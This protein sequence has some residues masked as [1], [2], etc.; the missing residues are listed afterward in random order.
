[1]LSH[2]DAEVGL[3]AITEQARQHDRKQEIKCTSAQRASTGDKEFHRHRDRDQGRDKHCHQ[4][5]A[6]EPV[7]E[8]A[9][10]PLGSFGLEKSLPAFPRDV[11]QHHIPGR[12][13]EHGERNQNGGKI[14]FFGGKHD[15]QRVHSDR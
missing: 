6:I 4:S 15:D 11:K 2:L 5:V 3:S 12:G 14:R 8:L 9:L 10:P 13:A 7:A 1:M